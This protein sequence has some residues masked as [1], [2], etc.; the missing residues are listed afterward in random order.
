MKHK[1]AGEEALARDKLSSRNYYLAGGGLLLGGATVLMYIF[2]ILCINPPNILGSF[3]YIALV[4]I[5]SSI[6]GSI[7]LCL[8]GFIISIIYAQKILREDDNYLVKYV[9]INPHSIILEYFDGHNKEIPYEELLNGKLTIKVGFANV[10]KEANYKTMDEFFNNTYEYIKNVIKKSKKPKVYPVIHI[11]KGSDEDFME[12]IMD[13]EIA[14]IKALLE[15]WRKNM[16]EYYKTRN[17][18]VVKKDK[19]TLK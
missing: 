13:P 14:D 17:S 5:Y 6:L 11:I 1:V 19:K 12:F 4:I 8:Y 15:D 2:I 10:L 7:G 18:P 16:N 3:S 9:H